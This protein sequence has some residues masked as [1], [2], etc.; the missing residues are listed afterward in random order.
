MRSWSLGIVLFLCC[1]RLL[2]Q[3]PPTLAVTISFSETPLAEALELLEAEYGLGFNYLAANIE[4]KTTSCEFQQADWKELSRCLFLTHGL[5]AK[6][7][8]QGYVSISVGVVED[9]LLQELLVVDLETVHVSEYVADGISATPD[10]RR[11]EIKPEKTP[12]IPGAADQELSR[13][14]SLLPGVTSLRESAGELSIRGGSRDH[15]LVLWDGI[16]IYSSGHY[17][18]MISNFNPELV[19]SVNLWR[20][21]AEAAYG[22]RVAGMIQMETSRDIAQSLSVG[23]GLSLLQ[24]SAFAK[25]PL[26]QKRSD[27]HLSFNGSLPPLLAGPAY[28]SYREQVFQGSQF[29]NILEQ[30]SSSPLPTDEDFRFQE[31]NGR[32][33]F[34]VSPRHRFT[35]SGFSQTDDFTYQ[36]GVAGRT[37]YYQDALFS[38]NLGGSL[39]YQQD[40]SG[41]RGLSVIMAVTDF[42]N[43]G[44]NSFNQGRALRT[45]S[46]SSNI[47]ENSLWLRYHQPLGKT[48]RLEVGGQ[49]QE[50]HNRISWKRENSLL[51]DRRFSFK[52]NNNEATAASFFSSYQWQPKG[53]WRAE[54]GLRIPYY[55]L[56]NQFYPEPRLSASVQL[57]KA[58]LLKAGYGFNHQFTQEIIN[59]NPDKIST[60]A[61]LWTLPDGSGYQVLKGREATFGFTGQ[62]RAWLFDVE[63]YHKQVDSLS[64]LRSNLIGDAPIVLRGDSRA[65]GVD[66][67]IKHRRRNWRSWAIYSLS[68]TKW[69][70]LQLADDQFPADNDRRHQLRLMNTFNVDR[71]SFSLAWR[72]QSGA[73]Y[74]PTDVRERIRIR[75]GAVFARIIRGDLNSGILPVYHRLDASVFYDWTAGV[76]KK[77]HGRIGLSLLNLYDRENFLERQFIVQR[78]EPV[79]TN[80]VPFKVEEITRTGLGF[81]PNLRASIGW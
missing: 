26:V 28:E 47:Q 68:S 13:I 12:P 57:S 75:D 31:F 76:N 49:V 67:L 62:A 63:F 9:S 52:S 33:Q 45:D 78:L 2:A 70:F 71:W 46:R 80:A 4:G 35:L 42:R 69:R 29:E 17:F 79:T 36:L 10:G 41:N 81:T 30:G 44:T 5:E 14:L 19:E 34:N 8:P 7:L 48:G 74:T 20:G 73:R 27:L 40:F 38:S 23:G 25:I 15:N 64:S 56:T 77:F 37:E 61:P 54:I 11:V 43:R 60:S 66:F 24:T 16:P 58:M 18:G 72:V 55:N 51:S 3:A 59:L 39:N 32:W 53:P 65:T 21:Q 22:G 1:G 50:Y 6:L